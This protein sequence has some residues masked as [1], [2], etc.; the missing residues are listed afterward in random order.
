MEQRQAASLFRI[1]A[2]QNRERQFFGHVTVRPPFSFLVWSATATLLALALVCFFIFGEYTKRARV[3]GV[4]TP[5]EGVIRLA[6]P[7]PGV[8]LER[9]AREGQKVKLGETIF[10][11]SSERFTESS[12]GTVGTNAAAIAQLNSRRNSL[13]ETIDRQAEFVELNRRAAQERLVAVQREVNQVSVELK[14]QDTR[15]S[16][17]RSQIQRLDDLEKQGF[18]SALGL[19]Q[20]RDEL[21]DQIG[22]FQALER[23][24]LSLQRD[25]NA[26]EAE[27]ARIPLQGAQQLAEFSREL[28]SIEQELV[29]AETGRQV[30]LRAPV[31]GVI[32]GILADPGQSVASQPLATLLPADAPLEAHLYAPSRAVGFIEPGQTVRIRF[33]AFPFQKFGQYAGTVA[34]VSRTAIGAAELTQHIPGPLLANERDGLYRIVVRLNSQSVTAYGKE[35]PL[36]SGMLLEADVMQEKRRLIE[37]ILD[38]LYSIGGKL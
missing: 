10:V 8:V 33:A 7:V 2:L 32:T 12:N 11:L 16:S 18:I 26:I 20:K 29:M 6:P 22:R 23:S 19:Q 4:T 5:S 3:F 24:R 9:R 21:I 1:E 27:L 28:A 31:D 15:T 34:F 37:W 38:P 17:L 36:T 25:A 14:T 13:K 30:V 35:Q